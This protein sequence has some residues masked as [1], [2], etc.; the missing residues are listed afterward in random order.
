MSEET[1]GRTVLGI[2][3]SMRPRSSSEAAMRAVLA[4]AVRRGCEVE[5]LTPSE[6]PTRPYDPG[7]LDDPAALPFVEAVRRCDAVVIASPGY[8][9]Q[10]SGLIKNVLDYTEEMRGDDP[11]YLDGKIVAPV[12][13]AHGWQAAVNTLTS[14]R[15]VIHAL[16]AWPTP[17]GL[18]L[19]TAEEGTLHDGQI[20]DR[21]ALE[22]IEL[23]ADQLLDG[24]PGAPRQNA[25]HGR[26]K[27]S[28]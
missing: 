21:R 2:G 27:E 10:L 11:P 6:F 13:V 15:Q 28:Q 16:R 23:M 5:A 17:L 9:G 25:S 8:H 24:P 1:K 7:T 12:A 20:V 3:G 14:L 26:E 4:A 18:A 19:N 22:T